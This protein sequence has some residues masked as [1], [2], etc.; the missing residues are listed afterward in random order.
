M[1]FFVVICSCCK[2][3]VRENIGFIDQLCFCFN[4]NGFSCYL[5]MVSYIVFILFLLQCCKVFIG[6]QMVNGL[7]K[8]SVKG[9][10][11]DGVFRIGRF[12]GVGFFTLGIVSL[13][14]REYFRRE[15]GIRL[16]LVVQGFFCFFF[17]WFYKLF[18]LRFLEEFG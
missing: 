18:F 5:L 17:W 8:V 1:F 12:S 9:V 2:R 7:F 13:V 15:L 10:E 3:R 11:Q 6:L 14:G 16:E 4:I